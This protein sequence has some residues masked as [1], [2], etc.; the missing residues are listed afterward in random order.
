LLA[1]AADPRPA[2]LLPLRLQQPS[3][4]LIAKRR[5]GATL[6]SYLT[7]ALGEAGLYKGLGELKALLER[8]RTAPPEAAEERTQLE[9]LIRAKAKRSTCSPPM[10]KPPT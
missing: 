2:E 8:W 7:P 3:E 10:T 9:D 1:R 6:I 4:G 5:G